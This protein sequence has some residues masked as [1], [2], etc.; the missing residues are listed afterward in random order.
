MLIF[1]I[2]SKEEKL[3]VICESLVPWVIRKQE[4]DQRH[5]FSFFFLF[6]IT[7]RFA[8]EY[9]LIENNI[10]EL[11][12]DSALYEELVEIAASGG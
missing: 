10:A 2:I 3:N 8:L 9:Y 5:C 1:L 4:F 6:E 11:V 12:I 7:A